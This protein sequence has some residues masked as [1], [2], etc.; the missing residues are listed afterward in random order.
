MSE[1]GGVG[2]HR[3]G[4]KANVMQNR[5][6][7][8]GRESLTVSGLWH[9]LRAGE[10]VALAFF[11]YAALA[12]LIFP[13]TMRERIGV[14]CL[15]ALVAAV[16]I[17][18]S[19]K[20]RRSENAFL[21]ALRDWLPC[22]LILV[23]YR[24]S[25]LFLLPDPAHRLDHL[26]ITWD[27]SL[28]GS[29]W[30]RSLVNL[31]SPWI[32]RFMEL[33]YLLV[34]PF[35]PLGFAAVYFNKRGARDPASVA[36][37]RDRFWTT[38][39][40]AVLA[41]YVM[42][43]YFPLTPPRVLFHDLPAPAHLAGTSAAP[44]LRKMNSWILD[45]YSVQACIFPSGHV[46]GAVATALAVHALRPRW[47]IVFLVAAASIAASTVFGRYHYSADALAGAIVGVIAYAAT[48]RLT[49]SETA[50]H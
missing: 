28:L 16:V 39:L 34:Y 49:R 48:K 12:A 26:F 10:K 27:R 17:A 50:S 38:V 4:R 20:L 46:A 43:P 6:A 42:F 18:L 23:A 13:L 30:F 33:A 7:N 44:F 8:L 25:G 24:E 9:G 40:L 32:E 11:T 36:S 31:C 1:S 21:G 14:W 22:V 35:V 37:A 5:I 15:N 19:R 47:G 45:R 2:R 41:S 29:A 3:L